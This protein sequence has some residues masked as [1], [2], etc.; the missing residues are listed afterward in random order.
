MPP[1]VLSAWWLLPLVFPV[2]WVGGALRRHCPPLA[3]FNIPVPVIGGLVFCLLVLALNVSG[4]ARF[5]FATRVSAGWWTWLTTVEPLWRANPSGS[6]NVLFLS[7]FFTCIGL[8]ATWRVVKAG[9]GALL[10]FW[11]LATLLG[12]LQNLLGAGLAVLMGAPPLLGVMCGAV[13][14]T[15][16]HG[17]ALGFA[18][19]F[20]RVGLLGAP[21]IGAAA[22]TFGLVAGGLLGGPLATWLIERHRL[23]VAGEETADTAKSVA[24][25]KHS[26][27]A[28][29]RGLWGL[30]R[31]AVPLLLVL[32]VALKVGAWVGYGLQ[33]AGLLFPA[34]MGAML[35]G[36]VIRNVHDALG[37]R[38]FDT[39]GVDLLGGFLLVVFLA[40]AMSSLNLIDLA[41]TAGPM[42][43]ILLVQVVGMA[44]FAVAVTYRA[45][46]RDYDAAM[47]SA[48][49]CGFGLGATSTAV[50]NMQSLAQRYG[51]S[52]RAF[53]IV[54]ATGALLIDVTNA[55]NITLFLNWLH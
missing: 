21:A 16:G 43:V 20:E 48:G 25:D 2:L 34:Y 28:Y 44:L 52:P 12:V 30:G 27:A 1:V 33:Q 36:I 49:H 18:P 54:P 8:N 55:I 24:N 5:S 14:L 51:A 9:S 15:G 46:G 26:L 41:S 11:G 3:R 10:L 6:L 17:T 22:A 39:A 31:R 7:G 40:I 47:M 4:V 37:L 53:L 35:T 29:A 23:A 42:L 45:M 38:W 50:A 32:A 19:E 13:T